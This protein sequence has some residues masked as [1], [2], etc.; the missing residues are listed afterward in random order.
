MSALSRRDAQAALASVQIALGLAERR[1]NNLQA[2]QTNLGLGSP[3][4]QA[5]VQLIN[6]GKTDFLPRGVL[7]NQVA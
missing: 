6:G 3:V 2:L 5:F 4:S 7:V 1:S